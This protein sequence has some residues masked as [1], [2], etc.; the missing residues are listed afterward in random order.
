MTSKRLR[1]ESAI[2]ETTR[3]PLGHEFHAKKGIMKIIKGPLVVMK[4]DKTIATLYMLHRKTYQ[5]TEIYVANSREK[6]TMRWHHKLSHMLENGLKILYNQKLLPRLKTISLP[7]YEHCVIIKQ[8]RLI[9]NRSTTRSKGILD[10]VHSN[11]W[12]SLATS[13]GGV[14]NLALFVNDYSRRCWV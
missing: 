8:H 13:L 11:V 3:W 9:F 6:L 1:E 7:F 10:F 4:V 2:N 14:N 5:E 12:E